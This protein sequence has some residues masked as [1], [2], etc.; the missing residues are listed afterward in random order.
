MFSQTDKAIARH[1]TASY[2]QGAST[3]D[4]SEGLARMAHSVTHSIMTRAR[5]GAS[6]EDLAQ[7]ADAFMAVLFPDPQPKVP[8]HHKDQ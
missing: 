1:L 7:I 3:F 8:Q 2:Q 4:D 5:A 6:R